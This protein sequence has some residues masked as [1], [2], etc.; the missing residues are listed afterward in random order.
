MSKSILFPSLL[1]CVVVTLGCGQ[2]EQ[3]SEVRSSEVSQPKISL[4]SVSINAPLTDEEISSF[5]QI[6]ERLP[7]KKIPTLSRADFS[8]QRVAGMTFES[9]VEGL[10]KS[11][12]AAMN[13]DEQAVAWNSE[14][15]LARRF[16]KSG[17][18]AEDFAA[19]ATKVSLAWSASS[20]QGVMPILYTRR[21]LD[22]RMQAVAIEFDALTQ[23]DENEAEVLQR[24]QELVALSE[25]LNLMREVPAESLAVIKTNDQELAEI[26]PR[27]D[28]ATQFEKFL[29]DAPEVTQTQY[30][31]H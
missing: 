25:F 2:T 24:T 16:S 20:V 26:L 12:R 17:V 19:L 18:A 9:Y 29:N 1:L 22:E 4:T 13:P 30:S 21:K 31:I 11:L 23:D 6:V 15:E 3:G 27:I 8:T 7:G 5:F 10:R 14:S 28:L